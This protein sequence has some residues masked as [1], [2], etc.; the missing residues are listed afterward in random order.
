[1]DREQLGQ[2]IRYYAHLLEMTTK[3]ENKENFLKEEEF[4]HLK[5]LLKEWQ[6]RGYEMHPDKVWAQKMMARY[7]HWSLGSGKLIDK[8]QS[9]EHPVIDQ[10]IFSVIQGRRSIRFWQRKVVP[11]HLMEKIIE[12]ATY[13]PCAFNRMTWKLIAVEN[14]LEAMVEGDSTNISMLSKAPVKIYIAI[15]ERLYE[16]TYAPALDAGLAL[17]NMLLA[18]HALGLGGC[19][20]YQGEIVDQEKLKQ[21]L[22]IAGYYQVYGVVLLGYPAEIPIPSA[23]VPV[24]EVS[25]FIKVKEINE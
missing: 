5:T 16:E 25:Q 14:E 1:M 9:P 3:C 10:G 18:A 13:A 23:R 12:A 20:V 19:L 21:Y 7:Q 24:K 17:Q 2:L 22:G 11:R 4:R 6:D 8:P 15:D